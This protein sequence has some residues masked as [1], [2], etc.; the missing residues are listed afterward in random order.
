MKNAFKSLFQ[1]LFKTTAQTSNGTSVT[2]GD[3]S[4]DLVDP[5]SM[6]DWTLPDPMDHLTTHFRFREMIHSNTA[7]RR[8]IDNT[9]RRIH[10]VR[11]TQLCREC[12]EPV[13][14]HFGSP[15]TIT[16]GYRSLKLNRAISSHDNSQHVK[17]EAA[18]FRVNGTALSTVFE[19]IVTE[20]NIPFD[21][22][23]YEFGESGWIHLSHT[24]RRPNRN[25]ILCAYNKENSVVY[26]QFNAHQIQ[27][28]EYRNRYN[29]GK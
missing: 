18:D 13:R 22:V 2:V 16:S 1:S 17:G 27:S 19:W 12:L 8:S 23:I 3:A 7:E 11:F 5:V 25:Q 4:L 9:P 24:M 20:S 28:Q 6:P 15:L 26:E 10:V 21:Q 29:T 14:T